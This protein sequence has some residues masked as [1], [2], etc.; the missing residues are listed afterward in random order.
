MEE[1]SPEKMLSE[2]YRPTNMSAFIGNEQQRLEMVKW[3]KNWKLG[4]KTLLLVGPPGVGKSTSIHALAREFG[5]TVIEFNASDVRT[6]DRLR[7][8]IGPTLENSTLFGE[9]KLV[10]ISRRDRRDLGKIWT[11]LAWIL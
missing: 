9:E 3:L 5:Y 7:E 6:R 11:T 1:I 10:G 4:S 2:I 8:A